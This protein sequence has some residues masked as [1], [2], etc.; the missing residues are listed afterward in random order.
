MI[1]KERLLLQ[2]RLTIN[3]RRPRETRWAFDQAKNGFAVGSL[4]YSAIGSEIFDSYGRKCNSRFFV[5][6]GFAIENNPDNEVYLSVSLEDHVDVNNSATQLAQGQKISHL[7]F[8]I[9]IS[10]DHKKTKDMFSLL[11]NTISTLAEFDE[12][13]GMEYTGPV[14]LQN[15]I[16]VLQLLAA[17]AKKTL[18]KF[19]HTLDY[20]NQLLKKFDQVPHFSNARNIV[21]MRRGEKEV[22][23][24]WLT[25]CATGIK[26]L[27]GLQQGKLYGG[28]LRCNNANINHYI[29]D[30]SATFCINEDEQSGDM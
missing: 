3:H 23:H 2:A 8:Q 13:N 9:P 7:N 4:Q 12:S 14:S 17:S 16:A 27:R 24:H 1:V 30:L 19:P 29:S 20:D 6:Y 11:R 18:V 22:L 5:N 26:Y 21:L 10:Y 25:L 28:Y 15:E